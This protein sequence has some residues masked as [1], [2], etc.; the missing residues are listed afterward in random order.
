[1]ENKC[2]RLATFP[3]NQT[4]KV[5]ASLDNQAFYGVGSL[6]IYKGLLPFINLSPK[7]SAC[8]FMGEHD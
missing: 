3:T 2:K 5:L 1:M 7:N 8:N 4:H 6:T